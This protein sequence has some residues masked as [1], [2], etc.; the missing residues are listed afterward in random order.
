MSS[1]KNALSKLSFYWKD[2]KIV[3]AKY[4]FYTL[5]RIILFEG[6]KERKKFAH[7]LKKFSEIAKG[8]KEIVFY[9][10]YDKKRKAK[11]VLP[12]NDRGLSVDLIANKIREPTEVSLFIKEV[13]PNMNIIDL[14]AN[15]GYYVLLERLLTK[16]NIYAI[17][18]NPYT[19]SFLRKSIT[20]NKFKNIKLFNIG[21]SNKKSKINF[22]LSKYLN[23]SRFNRYINNKDSDIVEIKK[24]K[25][26]SLDNL[27]GNKKIDLIRMDIEGYEKK[28]LESMD[29]ILKNNKNLKLFI[30]FH[31]SMFNKKERQEIINWIIKNN[32]KI[33]YLCHS[34]KFKVSK[35]H[36]N[37]NPKTLLNQHL[38]L[39]L[40]LE[41]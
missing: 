15:L 21:I 17:E 40:V 18:P 20:L 1:I 12:S 10:E 16:G 38:D 27:F 22:Y 29:K 6:Y 19:I 14:G 25:V 24:I 26:D 39:C 3:F 4:L 34:D 7:D 32:F 33:K 36:Y 41:R 13:K 8:K 30:E 5:K 2:N 9:I 28:V 23:W 37:V 31:T 11:I 35:I